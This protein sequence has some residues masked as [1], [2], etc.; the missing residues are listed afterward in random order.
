MT[1]VYY[2]VVRVARLIPV[3]EH[4][5][6]RIPSIVGYVVTLSAILLFICKRLGV[7]AGLVGVLFISLT[8]VPTVRIRGAELRAFDRLSRGRHGSVAA[9]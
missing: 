9:S 7:A 1:P 2:A 5:A 8:P 3:N 6:V 4:I